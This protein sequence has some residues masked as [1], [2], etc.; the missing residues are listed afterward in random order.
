MSL[1]R[2]ENK[3]FE[4]PITIDLEPNK[5]GKLKLFINKKIKIKIVP[6]HNHFLHL[7]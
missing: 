7:T 3:R 1:Q 5:F 4:R 6:N 2:Y